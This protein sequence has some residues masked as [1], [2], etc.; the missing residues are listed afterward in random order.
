MRHIYMSSVKEEIGFVEKAAK[1][2]AEHPEHNTYTD[3]EIV[4]GGMFAVRW[5][6]G[7]DCV[8][9]MKLD[10]S[11][12]PTVYGQLIRAFQPDP[13]RLAAQP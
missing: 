13:S 11:F 5:G 3:G 8:L 9:V 12:E 2:F 7:D 4:S 6:L 10:D 1:H